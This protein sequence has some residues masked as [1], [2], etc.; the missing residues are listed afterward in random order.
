[1]TTMSSG[2]KADTALY[3]CLDGAYVI[4]WLLYL[5]TVVSRSCSFW[6]AL[7]EALRLAPWWW[8]GGTVVGGALGTLGCAQVVQ[9]GGII[10]YCRSGGSLGIWEVSFLEYSFLEDFGPV[11]RAVHCQPANQENEGPLRKWDRQPTTQ[12]KWSPPAYRLQKLSP[13]C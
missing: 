2:W 7:Q 4:A 11:K 10:M 1:M 5:A 12:R 6:W 8:G 9:P 3:Q 13:K